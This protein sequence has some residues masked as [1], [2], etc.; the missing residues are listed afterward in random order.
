MQRQSVCQRLIKNE[1]DLKMKTTAKLSFLK[2]V[3][4]ENLKWKVEKKIKK[5]NIKTKMKTN[6]KQKIEN[7]NIKT[8]GPPS[9]I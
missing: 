3:E 5:L 8:K 6:Q 7:E 1:D 9:K 2:K 4:N